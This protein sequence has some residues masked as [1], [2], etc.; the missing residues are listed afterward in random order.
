MLEARI[1]WPIRRRSGRIIL[2]VRRWLFRRRRRRRRFQSLHVGRMIV[3]DH[4]RRRLGKETLEAIA[5]AG[6]VLPTSCCRR[7]RG[8]AAFVSGSAA[9]SAGRRRRR[10]QPVVHNA[11][12]LLVGRHCSVVVARARSCFAVVRSWLLILRDRGQESRRR[13]RGR[14]GNIGRHFSSSGPFEPVSSVS[15]SGGNGSD[16]R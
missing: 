10:P 7:R 3:T 15:E 13:F 9:A 5:A 6:H 1:G 16:S 14:G 4:V 12:A 11:E 2:L 8:M